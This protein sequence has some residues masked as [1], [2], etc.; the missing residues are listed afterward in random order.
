MYDARTA[1]RLLR[2][3]QLPRFM[4]LLLAVDNFA[5]PF[6]LFNCRPFW[7]YGGHYVVLALADR[8]PILWNTRG[9]VQCTVQMSPLYI[10]VVRECRPQSKC[11]LPAWK[12]SISQMCVKPWWSMPMVV[13]S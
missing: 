5:T 3:R 1:L 11:W 12:G 13:Q 2:C 8:R 4:Q 10:G 7:S 6:R 9:G